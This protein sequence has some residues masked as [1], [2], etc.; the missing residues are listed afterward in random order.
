MPQI[1]R[2]GRNPRRRPPTLS[3]YLD[4]SNK[5]LIIRR[6]GG[7]GD[8]LMTRML[9]FDIK[10]TSHGN[11]VYYACPKNYWPLVQD[12]PYI[13]GLLDCFTVD[14][15]SYGYV[16]DLTDQCG[17]YETTVAPFIDKH[18][19]DIWANHIGIKLTQHEG[20]LSFTEPELTQAKNRLQELN[21]EG[22]PTCVISPITAHPGKDLPLSLVS[23]VC[24]GLKDLGYLP[25]LFHTHPIEIEGVHSI[26]HIGLREWMALVSLCDVG[27]TAATA[28]YCLLNLLH[29]PTVACFGCE[30]L[31]IYGRYFPEMLPVQRHRYDRN[32]WDNCP[33]WCCW[34]CS[35]KTP[36]KYPPACIES[37]T[38]DEVLGTFER[39]IG[40]PARKFGV[41][42]P[43]NPINDPILPVIREQQ[44]QPPA[45]REIEHPKNTT[46]TPKPNDDISTT[47]DETNHSG[48][49]THI[50]LVRL[51]LEELI[52]ALPA[53]ERLGIDGR[54]VLHGGPEETEDLFVMD[55]NITTSRT[56]AANALMLEPHTP[57]TPNP[58][59][60]YAEQLGVSH[61]RNVPLVHIPLE[62]QTNWDRQWFRIKKYFIFANVE[63]GWNELLVKKIARKKRFIVFSNARM[64]PR[65]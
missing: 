38:P 6:Q 11:K 27:I 63:G 37:M 23:A 17:L 65:T 48:I 8:I 35:Y 16:S 14:R 42:G 2:G 56:E 3:N 54:V 7:A 46:C 4:N 40:Q 61:Y 19:S 52:P 55:P 9:F 34:Q 59:V 25:I 53:I 24:G 21:P 47:H 39:L 57:E 64:G 44:Q 41:N 60:F 13:D 30:D 26:H 20:H 33:C 28:T 1:R 32:G 12:H 43:P 10:R 51:G 58:I 15:N 5:I 31:E 45:V 50:S 62:M 22:K 29:K 18:R 36:G 49:E